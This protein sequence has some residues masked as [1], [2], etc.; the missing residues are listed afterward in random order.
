MD[1]FTQ[2]SHIR[3]YQ[4]LSRFSKTNKSKKPKVA[5]RPK[6]DTLDK[7]VYIISAF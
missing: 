4:G 3:F 1:I 6:C 2:G 7:Q 5:K